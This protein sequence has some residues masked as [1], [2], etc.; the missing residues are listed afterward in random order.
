MFVLI[1]D[2]V[3]SLTHIVSATHSRRLAHERVGAAAGM[4]VL[5]D[6]PA[7]HAL[8]TVKKPDK[9][10]KGADLHEYF[11]TAETANKL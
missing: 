10:K 6:T 5:F 3:A 4:L 2:D 1:S 11:A 8:F 9:L 7:G